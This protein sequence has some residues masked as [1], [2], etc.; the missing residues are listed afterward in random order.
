MPPR[1]FNAVWSAEIHFRFSAFGFATSGC[2]TSRNRK[3]AIN[4]R[5]PKGFSLIEILIVVL[6][7]GVLTAALLPYFESS[8]PD[9]LESAAQI[10]AADLDYARSLAIA[11]G[12]KYRITFDTAQQQ[13]ILEHSGANTLLDE[14]PASPFRKPGD[15]PD[16]HIV[17]LA[18]LPHLG[19]A[20][21]IAGLRTGGNAP[22]TVTD[23][24]FDA[25]GA[26]TR[27]ETTLVWLAAGEGA[28][29]MYVAVEV[30]PVTG[31]ATVGEFQTARPAGVSN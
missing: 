21:E 30:D 13:Y 12:S 9:Q 5:T 10:V 26:V 16:Q 8:T 3:A 6:I 4:R 11:G 18:H 15:P 24:E 23:V 27:S 28:D 14:L 2:E 25:V 7:M 31:L 20:V 29:R 17:D 1:S 19:A 22:Q